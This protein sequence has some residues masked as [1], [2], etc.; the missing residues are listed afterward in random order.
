MRFY[1]VLAVANS[2]TQ[3]RNRNN[4]GYVPNH[5]HGYCSCGIMIIITKKFGNIRAVLYV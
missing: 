1:L 2:I 3:G 5:G 4:L